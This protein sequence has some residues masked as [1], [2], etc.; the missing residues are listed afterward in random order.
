MPPKFPNVTDQNA[1]LEMRT[2]IAHERAI[3][4]IAIE[5]EKGQGWA[6]KVEFSEQIQNSPLKSRIKRADVAKFDLVMPRADLDVDGGIRQGFRRNAINKFRNHNSAPARQENVPLPADKGPRKG[7][8]NDD[9]GLEYGDDRPQVPPRPAQDEEPANGNW[10]AVIHGAAYDADS[11][12]VAS[13]QVSAWDDH[14]P[15]GLAAKVN[16]YDEPAAVEAYFEP[17]A[18]SAPKPAGDRAPRAFDPLGRDFRYQQL[19]NFAHNTHTLVG[20]SRDEKE[21]ASKEEVYRFNHYKSALNRIDP[22][23]A[24]RN[25][26]VDVDSPFYRTSERTDIHKDM[27]RAFFH[28][29]MRAA[30][31]ISPDLREEYKN[32]TMEERVTLAHAE[33]KHKIGDMSK[34]ERRAMAVDMARIKACRVATK[35]HQD[36]RK[37]VRMEV[38]DRKDPHRWGMKESI[39]KAMDGSEKSR[40][41]FKNLPSRAVKKG[42]KEIEFW[43]E[44]LG[45]EEVAK[46]KQDFKDWCWEYNTS[47]EPQIAAREERRTAMSRSVLQE[48]GMPV[49][50]LEAEDAERIADAAEEE[51]A[52]ARD[53]S[54]WK[55]VVASA[56][57]LLTFG[58]A[59]HLSAWV[60]RH[61][62]NVGTEKNAQKLQSQLNR[63]IEDRADLYL[64]EEN[65]QRTKD[66]VLEQ[67][68]FEP[69]DIRKFG[70]EKLFDPLGFYAAIGNFTKEEVIA[71]IREQ[72]A[73][74]EGHDLNNPPVDSDDPAEHERYLAYKEFERFLEPITAGIFEGMCQALHESA[75][76]QLKLRAI[77][78]ATND[79]DNYVVVSNAMMRLNCEYVWRQVGNMFS[80]YNGPVRRAGRLHNIEMSSREVA[81][82]DGDLESSKKDGVIVDPFSGGHGGDGD[83]TQEIM[84]PVAGARREALVEN[85]KV[86]KSDIEEAERVAKE[87]N[88][89]FGGSDDPNSML[90]MQATLDKALFDLTFDTARP[91]ESLDD[92]SARY[93][94]F[95]AKIDAL[96]ERAEDVRKLL[97]PDWQDRL[98]VMLDD[99]ES[100][101]DNLE[102]LHRRIVSLEDT[103]AQAQSARQIDDDSI[104]RFR[105]EM[106]LASD[107]LARTVDGVGGDPKIVKTCLKTLES[108][109]VSLMKSTR[110]MYV[111]AEAAEQRLDQL[112]HD[113]KSGK[114]SLR[115]ASQAALGTYG[116]FMTNHGAYAKATQRRPAFADKFDAMPLQL[117]AQMARLL[118]AALGIEMKH[119]ETL[120][121]E[122]VHTFMDMAAAGVADDVLVDNFKFYIDRLS[123]DKDVTLRDV[124]DTLSMIG[125]PGQ[126][127]GAQDRP[128]RLFASQAFDDKPE[129]ELIFCVRMLRQR[130]RSEAELRALEHAYFA[131]A[132]ETAVVE[133]Q[134]S[135]ET[136]RAALSA[137][138]APAREPAAGTGVDDDGIPV[139]ED[140][141]DRVDPH[142][143]VGSDDDQF[144]ISD[145]DDAPV[146]VTNKIIDDVVAMAPD[147]PL[148]E[149]V[150]MDWVRLAAQNLK[151]LLNPEKVDSQ[152]AEDMARARTF[153]RMFGSVTGKN[154]GELRTT[155]QQGQATEIENQIA[156]QLSFDV[157]NDLNDAKKMKQVA[158]NAV[159]DKENAP[160]MRHLNW[161]SDNVLKLMHEQRQEAQLVE[162]AVIKPLKA[163][164]ELLDGKNVETPEQ[165]RELLESKQF[166]S[167]A[168]VLEQL[169][170]FDDAYSDIEDSDDRGDRSATYDLNLMALKQ[171]APDVR[172]FDPARMEA[173]NRF[174]NKMK[175]W[176]NEEDPRKTAEN[177]LDDRNRQV[178]ERFENVWAH[179]KM[180]NAIAAS[181]D[182]LVEDLKNLQGQRDALLSKVQL[183]CQDQLVTLAIMEEFKA[184]GLDLDQFKLDAAA[185]D[186]IKDRL[187]S[188]GQR[189]AWDS[190]ITRN[191]ELLEGRL[192]RQIMDKWQ[193]DSVGLPS[194]LK[195]EYRRL[196]EALNDFEE[197]IRQYQADGKQ[198]LGTPLDPAVAGQFDTD[199]VQ[200]AVEALPR[201]AAAH[202]FGDML[203]AGAAWHD[204]VDWPGATAADMRQMTPEAFANELKNG[205]VGFADKAGKTDM[206]RKQTDA[207]NANDRTWANGLA[208]IVDKAER[209]NALVAD[210]LE[211]K[212]ALIPPSPSRMKDLEA[213]A[214]EL[215]DSVRDLDPKQL[216]QMKS[217]RYRNKGSRRA[218]YRVPTKHFLNAVDKA[219]FESIPR[220]ADRQLARVKA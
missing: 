27:G 118:P 172:G 180:L 100:Q 117:E 59:K 163:F 201:E 19:V 168:R 81:A 70:H 142:R 2:A 83:E 147:H 212:A 82:I 206:T 154:I 167:K 137:Q 119:D 42:L 25:R 109:M 6:A 186:N 44:P 140:Y 17:Q 192:T 170:R 72:V 55:S 193:A 28:E 95:G 31:Y 202:T 203:S 149:S 73:R 102:D 121:P 79:A 104:R 20:D 22:Q 105:R 191:E 207:Q 5:R 7:A 156:A 15:A 111:A 76:D 56:A 13:L 52:K 199:E 173:G 114:T 131:K 80:D 134:E 89:L 71:N 124:D 171:I 24:V 150:G 84:L 151:D 169:C 152:P 208:Q 144:V 51:F 39:A 97:Q 48:L 190:F 8:G 50:L 32:L 108:G 106:T 187:Q 57:N 214:K 138:A 90:G 75:G 175:I 58:G 194:A 88:N 153:A 99:F 204:H 11:G 62:E 60:R 40:D 18:G 182:L 14:A 157:K 215:K 139:I 183:H 103:L 184:S 33:L 148:F 63:T 38:P 29:R 64:Y 127:D 166:R 1:Q 196:N 37:N 26:G 101:V 145:V 185:V 43:A 123:E 69:E 9:V 160:G 34:S 133:S 77:A 45:K 198:F 3:S 125:A 130:G 213:A 132:A 205:L 91:A 174:I 107:R 161:R 46:L 94:P 141:F 16:A 113:V 65:V 126:G 66:W 178:A 219:L 12:A 36:D 47:L 61:A 53:F 158:T 74:S 200:G 181:N 220:M 98:D 135:V 68:K 122:A 164:A 159:V 195:D 93:A 155:I 4:P 21:L 136:A 217:H 116:T 165:V 188:W 10:Q 78:A 143:V 115:E 96:R 92:V 85:V 177:V 67:Y 128:L 162:G 218:R 35:R 210:T 197:L 49:T 54:L 179:L 209:F 87:L 120:S 41:K 146:T 189:S 211:K 129:A 176:W 110:D 86:A 112:E 216:D 30:G 23:F